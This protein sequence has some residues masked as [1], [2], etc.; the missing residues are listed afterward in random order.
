MKTDTE[1]TKH[2]ASLQSEKTWD[3]CISSLDS[4][5][6]TEE[7]K[8]KEFMQTTHEATL[9]LIQETENVDVGCVYIHFLSLQLS[10]LLLS[11]ITIY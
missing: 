5:L 7:N 6:N 10:S 3:H 1:D 11:I 8:K 9:E 2:Y 4:W